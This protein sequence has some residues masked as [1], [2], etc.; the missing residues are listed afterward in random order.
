VVP[1]RALVP[2]L[3]L[4]PWA[5]CCYPSLSEGKPQQRVEAKLAND[6]QLRSVL[7]QARDAVVA[8]TRIPDSGYASRIETDVERVTRY[9]LMAGNR[10]DVLYLQEHVGPYAEKIRGVLLPAETL[11][12]FAARAEAAEQEDKYRHDEDIE[13]IVE[14][15]IQNG[16]LEDALRNAMRM[17]LRLLQARTMAGVALS[18]LS[19]G[20]SHVAAS[21]VEAALEK[22][23][24]NQP[25]PETFF[26]HQGML[27]EL[28]QT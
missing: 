1:M 4:I 10:A 2:S 12:D 22:K 20:N 16:F 28:A 18:A 5:A 17:Q 25:W 9:L 14:Q 19:R 23:A 27:L 11:A 13:L 24:P 8:E 6:V 3:I 15:E 21:A 7:L 26:D